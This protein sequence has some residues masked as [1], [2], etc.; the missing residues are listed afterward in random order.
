MKFRIND[1]VKHKSRIG[2][3]K[4]VKLLPNNICFGH[5]V[6]AYVA[7]DMHNKHTLLLHEGLL[8]ETLNI[9]QIITRKYLN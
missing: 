9:F 5:R 1:I 6:P 2:L 7:I 8:I 3:F 4:I